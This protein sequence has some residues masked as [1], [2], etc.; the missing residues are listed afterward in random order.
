MKRI[1]LD[2]TDEVFYTLEK[3]A[4]RKGWT[5]AEFLRKG[6]GLLKY[7][8]EERDKG[9]KIIVE[10]EDEKKEIISI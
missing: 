5:K 3:I 1:T 4:A 6:M 10:N 2:L 7:F 9:S 8:E